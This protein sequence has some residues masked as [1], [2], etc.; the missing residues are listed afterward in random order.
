MNCSEQAGRYLK[1][2][3]IQRMRHCTVPKLT[4]SLGW[5]RGF[6]IIYGLDSKDV[7]MNAYGWLAKIHSESGKP[8]F[9]IRPKLHAT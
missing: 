4:I 3:E 9:P 7:F 8:L 1:D 2:E 5:H 6:L